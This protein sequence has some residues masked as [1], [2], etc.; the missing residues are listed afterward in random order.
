MKIISIIYRM[1]ILTSLS[2]C[3]AAPL[4]PLPDVTA[5]PTA[6]PNGPEVGSTAVAGRDGP[7]RVASVA[8]AENL[9]GFKIQQPSYLPDGVSLDFMTYQS[10]LAPQVTLHYKIVHPQFGDMG[11][12]FQLVQVPQ[13]AAPPDTTS[14]A[15]TTDG[16]CEV[17][18]IG[19]TPIVYHHY[20]GGTEGLDWHR[21]GFAFR[22]LRTAG[23]PGKVYKDEL[24]QVVASLIKNP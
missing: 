5:T 15:T 11:G 3:R 6:Q 14:C 16:V 21:D 1:L 22:L 18:S 4:A 2:A 12:F 24:V 9:A 7:L 10:S 23:E 13:S 8:E 19:A 20:S 17:L